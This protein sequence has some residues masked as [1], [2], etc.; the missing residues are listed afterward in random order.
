M[1]MLRSVRPQVLIWTILPLIAL[2]V[3]VAFGSIALHEDHMRMMVAESDAHL[4]D[5]GAAQVAGQ[6]QRL[7]SVLQ[8]VLPAATT[9]AG[10]PALD[11]SL[12]RDLDLGVALF[13]GDRR[14]AATGALATSMADDQRAALADARQRPDGLAVRRVSGTDGLLLAVAGADGR[15]VAL[16]AVS[17]AGMD[18]QGVLDGL[19][20]GA[21]ASA[22]IAGPDGAVYSAGAAVSGVDLA[23]PAAGH[24][25]EAP[26][27]VFRRDAASGGEHVTAYAPIGVADWMLV[28]DEPLQD[29]LVPVLRYTLL[30]PLLVLLAAVLSLVVV[31]LGARLVVRPLQVLGDRSSRLAWGD[32]DAISQPVG[33]IAAIRDLQ[34]TLG[35]MAGRIRGYQAAMQDYIASLTQAQEDERRRLAREL[36]DDTAQ[37][38][39]ALAQRVTLVQL[40]LE[41][42]Q[43][44]GDTTRLQ[45]AAQQVHELSGMVNQA[46][47]NVREILQALRPAA[48][49]EVGL[50]T[51]LETLAARAT[52]QTLRVTMEVAGAPRRLAADKELSLYRLAQE[53][54]NNVARHA[55]ASQAVLRLEFAP[56]AVTLTIRDNGVGFHA[57]H[58]PSDL[59]R[60]GHY[61]LLGMHE[62]ALLLGGHL[63][64]SSAPGAGATLTVVVPG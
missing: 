59:A 32:F 12:L 24:H 33:G 46:L 43:Q 4:T 8:T 63:T 18:V 26:R 39:I 55:Q 5:V 45:Q 9:G 41:D 37:N 42:A 15:L 19:L 23:G 44:A 2:L 62:R 47:A 50:A 27:S 56:S 57:P 16:G 28:L 21:H 22:W 3:I 30:A 58:A 11:A 10:S 36:H 52:S 13:D 54:L 40:A 61:G 17:A 31:Y 35:E 60:E 48:L 14:V 7:A 6:V 49:D 29:V 34:T 25:G 53:G 38:L 64:I 51:A 20:P 1:N